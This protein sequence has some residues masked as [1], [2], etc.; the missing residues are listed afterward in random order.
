MEPCKWATLPDNYWEPA[1]VEARANCRALI[2]G[3]LDTDAYLSW[4]AIFGSK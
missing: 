3:T 2:D 1:E 4:E